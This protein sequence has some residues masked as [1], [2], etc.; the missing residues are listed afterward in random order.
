M[1]L[2]SLALTQLAPNCDL[3][4]P[5]EA[6]STIRFDMVSV[7]KVSETRYVAWVDVLVDTEETFQAYEMTLSWDPDSLMTPS[8][9]AYG[10]FDDDGRFSLAPTVGSG[11]TST[12]VDLRHGGPK[13]GLTRVAKLFIESPNGEPATISVTGHV[14]RPD[15]SL[16]PLS[17]SEPVAI[18]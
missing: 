18:P 5:P 3:A 1:T 7:L 2:A 10:D 11:G 8:V 4:A 16:I 17:A 14:A 15:G 12:F 9:T 6:A 13:A